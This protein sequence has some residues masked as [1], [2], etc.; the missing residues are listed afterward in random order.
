MWGRRIL[1]LLV[2]L[3]AFL[4]YIFNTHYLAAFCFWAVLAAPVLSLL[5][6][7]PVL[8]TCRLELRGV[9]TDVVRGE[10]G[11]WEVRL[12]GRGRL[13][14]ARV[15]FT[16]RLRHAMDGE[17]ERLRLAYRGISPKAVWA[18]PVDGTH[19][20][21]VTG[22]LTSAW[23]SDLLRL[24]SLPLRRSPAVTV[25]VLPVSSPPAAL[26]REWGNQPAQAYAARSGQRM[27]E[28]YEL[29]DYRPGDPIRS[30]HW[31]LSS[32]R[33]DPIVRESSRQQRPTVLLT[34]D[35]FGFPEEAD[36]TLDRL[37]GWSDLLLG[38]EFPHVIQWVHPETGALRTHRI[39]DRFSQYLCME[40]LLED[41]LPPVG[42]T[43]RDLPLKDRW[44]GEAV[45]PIHI[46]PG[47]EADHET[48]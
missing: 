22:T 17:V 12:L 20:E 21:A 45:Y 3:G 33:D 36:R 31:K 29:R 2:L 46:G 15:A 41:P 38:R 7:L 42:R 5:L 1:Y 19:C 43:V 16:I 28:E 10:E 23:A 13:P 25:L 27:G 32:K 40:A 44:Q 35:R 24:F 6:S 11:R 37:L 8:L 26:P 9:P 48:A 18:E 34:V 30:V 47:E 39:V 4:V 14:L